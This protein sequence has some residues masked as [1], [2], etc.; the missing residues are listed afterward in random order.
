MLV[1]YSAVVPTLAVIAP[2]RRLRRYKAEV[3]DKAETRNHHNKM[4]ERE[5]F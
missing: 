3:K 5:F 4:S 1:T 2:V